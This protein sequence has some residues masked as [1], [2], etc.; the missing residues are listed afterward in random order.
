M[1]GHNSGPKPSG[2]D[3]SEPTKERSDESAEDRALLLLIRAAAAKESGRLERPSDE[4]LAAYMTGRA[5]EDQKAQVR[6]ALRASL[7]LR[8][9]VEGLYE[10]I[11]HLDSDDARAAFD[12]AAVPAIERFPR[13]V[14]ARKRVTHKPA[15]FAWLKALLEEWTPRE[16]AFAT[17]TA[18]ATATCAV[19][20]VLY[21]AS[22]QP[23]DLVLEAPKRATVFLSLSPTRGPEVVSPSTVVPPETRAL[24]L[25][26]PALPGVLPGSWVQ[27]TIVGPDERKHRLAPRLAAD[28]SNSTDLPLELCSQRGALAAG[29]YKL[30]LSGQRDGERVSQEF[31]FNLSIAGQ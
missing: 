25:T 20:A 27:M 23:S 29:E 30:I 18:V 21:I 11:E 9:E 5:T 10:D 26:I 12:R 4:A 31:R 7:E 8:D 1:R 22:L 28:L 2:C 13:L 24:G 15:P 19:L 6:A 3:M 16:G 17:V 14:Q